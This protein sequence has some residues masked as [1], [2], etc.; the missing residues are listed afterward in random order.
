MRPCASRLSSGVFAVCFCGGAAL[1]ADLSMV[2]QWTGQYPSDE[3][4]NGKPLWDQPGVQEAVRAA[5][6]KYFFA[7]LK[8]DKNAP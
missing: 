4:V 3:I 8:K 1:A 2:G 5:M 6:G 7:P